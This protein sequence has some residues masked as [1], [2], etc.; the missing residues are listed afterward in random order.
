MY[1][2][3]IICMLGY[4]FV[5]SLQGADCACERHNGVGNNDVAML[6]VSYSTTVLVR[7]VIFLY[8]S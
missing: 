3:R 6:R 7:K 2:I 5:K 1:V 4:V 8:C